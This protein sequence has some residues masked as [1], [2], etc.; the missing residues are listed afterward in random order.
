[1]AGFWDW[2]A[3]RCQLLQIELNCLTD[4]LLGLFERIAYSKTAG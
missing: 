1:M 4:K 2:Q 3:I